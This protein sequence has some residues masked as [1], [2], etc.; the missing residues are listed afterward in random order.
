MSLRWRRTVEL[1]VCLSHLSTITSR[2]LARQ[3]LHQHLQ[4]AVLMLHNYLSLQLDETA[5]PGEACHR[6]RNSSSCT[7]NL[8]SRAER[9][10]GHSRDAGGS[11]TTRR[12]RGGTNVLSNNTGT[13]FHDQTVTLPATTS[14][15]I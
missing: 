6:E 11:A 10:S 12:R 9:V 2:S 15:Y 4:Q 7:V 8:Q 14:V 3:S 1:P 13:D 5:G